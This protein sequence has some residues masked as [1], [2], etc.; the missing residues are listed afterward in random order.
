MLYAHTN[1]WLKVTPL[2]TPLQELSLFLGGGGE[3][4]GLFFEFA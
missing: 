4:R 1:T 2:P 3:G